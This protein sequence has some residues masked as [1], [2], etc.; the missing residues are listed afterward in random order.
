MGL[1]V[2][3]LYFHAKRIFYYVRNFESHDYIVLKFHHYL[4]Y[5][6]VH[7]HPALHTEFNKHLY[8]FFVQVYEYTIIV[9]THPERIGNRYNLRHTFT[10]PFLLTLMT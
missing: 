9:K 6:T 5:S 4:N 2:I 7:L 1:V 8:F 10:G 3:E